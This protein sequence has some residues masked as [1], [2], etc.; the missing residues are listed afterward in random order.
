LGVGCKYRI[1]TPERHLRYRTID[2]FCS[3]DGLHARHLQ[4]YRG[5]DVSNAAMGN[6]GSHHRAMPLPVEIQ[7]VDELTPAAHKAQIFD[8]LNWASDEGVG[9][10]HSSATA[11]FGNP[12]PLMAKLRI[13]GAAHGCDCLL[14]PKPKLIP[15]YALHCRRECQADARARCPWHGWTGAFP[16]CPGRQSCLFGPC[17]CPQR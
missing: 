10:F 8:S 17:A 12:R 6:G 5:V 13:I 4:R 11:L 16:W 14:G 1:G 7:V 15:K 3:D 9:A 2:V